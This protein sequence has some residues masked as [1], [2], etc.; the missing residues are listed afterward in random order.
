MHYIMIPQAEVF[1][2]EKYMELPGRVYGYFYLSLS[3]KSLLFTM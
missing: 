3:P 2:K 1:V